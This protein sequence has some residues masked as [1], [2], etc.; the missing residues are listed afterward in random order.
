MKT[1]KADEALFIKLGGGGAWDRE[2][3][4]QGTLRLDYRQ[5]PHDLCM[6][7]KWV[8]VLDHLQ[9]TTS[10]KGAAQ[11]HADQIRRFYEASEE[12]L[13]ITFSAGR[14]HW[15]FAKSGV[16]VLPDGTRTRKV[17]GKWKDKSLHGKT[18]DTKNL[19]GR[20]LAT[21]GFRGTICRAADLTYLLNKINGIVSPQV[22]AV[23]AAAQKLEEA[24]I[25]V[26]QTLNP[27]DLETLVD[28]I[29]RQ[30]GWSRI[31]VLGGVEKDIDLSLI[32]SFSDQRIA[33][34][35]KSKADLKI[36]EAYKQKFDEMAGYAKFYFVT[37]SPNAALEKIISDGPGNDMLELWDAKKLANYAFK[38]G[39][40]G[41]LLDKAG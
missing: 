14:L 6:Q 13:W 16:Q 9:K 32:S 30:G 29:F 26:I 20:V 34:Q 38:H 8:Q 10:N 28:Q 7:G 11:R 35:I 39:L 17:M 27:K 12:T 19:N 15:C 25:P 1:I 21:Q 2:C 23:E 31:G 37:H 22:T 36:F 3:F 41:W 5:V 24:L 4:E 40:V 18:L 33:V